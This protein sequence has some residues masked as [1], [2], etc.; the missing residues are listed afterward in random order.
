MKILILVFLLLN[1]TSVL[2][3]KLGSISVAT[4]SWEG[5]TN[6]DG[7]GLYFDILRLVYEP[8]GIEVKYT[9]MPYKRSVLLVAAKQCDA[10]VAS[11]DKEQLDAIYPK[12][13]LGY[14]EVVALY[15]NKTFPNWQGEATLENKYLA[16]IR[17]YGYEDYLNVKVRWR[18]LTKRDE[19]IPILELDRIHA[20][21]DHAEDVQALID[22]SKVDM[23]RYRIGLVFRL[24]LFMGYANTPK[25]QLLA[26]IWDERMETIISTGELRELWEKG[27]NTPY[28]FEN[29]S[30]SI[31]IQGLR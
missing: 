22:K 13:K 27:A 11:Y 1:S 24:D 2:A 29:N 30:S 6:L 9:I 8:I 17:G 19:V 12:K 28:P 15:K 5:Y 3:E 20:F 4:A 25:G 18:E 21:L 10:W 16:W 31:E 14:D 23:N 26:D 7:T